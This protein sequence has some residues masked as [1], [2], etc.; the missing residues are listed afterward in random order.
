MPWGIRRPEPL[1]QCGKSN[2]FS[3]WKLVSIVI[4][5]TAFLS[6]RAG[7]ARLGFMTKYPNAY[8]TPSHR[9]H[10]KAVEDNLNSAKLAQRE[11]Q[12]QLKSESCPSSHLGMCLL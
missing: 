7:E 12:N 2:H 3:L 5:L 10:I 11:V 8:S 1:L 4:M 9:N 6:S